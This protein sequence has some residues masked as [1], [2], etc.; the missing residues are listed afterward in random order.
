MKAAAILAVVLSQ[1]DARGVVT[2]AAHTALLAGDKTK[3]AD[4]KIS[5]PLRDV[6]S[7]KKFFGPPFPADYPED[8]RPVPDRS[9]LNKL[10]GPDQPYPAL[11]SKEDFD[12]DY[13]KDENSDTGAWRA[14][15]EYDSLRKRLANEDA[16]ARAASGAADA[17][18]K[19][20]ED[21]QHGADGAAADA[22]AARK[23]LDDARQ[24]EKDALTPEEA[25]AIPDDTLKQKKEKLEKLEKAV[26]AAEEK[27]KR[28]QAQFE[29][30][31]QKLEEA[32][33]NLEELKQA[34]TE[35][36]AKLAADTKLWV[37]TKTTRLNAKKAKEEAAKSAHAAK[38][39][40]VNA[41]LKEA[42]DSK[43]DYDKVLAEKKAIHAQ[44]QEHLKKQKAE[45]DAAKTALDKA[46]LTLQKIRG[47]VPVEAKKSGS[48]MTSIFAVFSG[49][50]ALYAH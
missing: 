47:Y 26:A 14:Q 48:A 7:D 38:M 40:A 9:I 42:Q 23:G 41:K 20:L 8:T 22:D 31:K 45:Y 36:E 44:A 49:L 34:Q 10:K 13:V 27:F 11:Q 18:K 6:K 16:A 28:E 5:P 1:G 15:F 43:A 29:V 4:P 19:A 35:M 39:A 24:G 21:A 32:K 12:K 37:E 33:K 25:E 2:P 30:C 3:A 46:T 50:V 17:S